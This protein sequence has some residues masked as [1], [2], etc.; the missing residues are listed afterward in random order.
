[1]A[2]VK[3]QGRRT[4]R[5]VFGIA[6]ALLALAPAAQAQTRPE[7]V[8][9]QARVVLQSDLDLPGNDLS[10]IRQVGQDA[11]VQAC[12]A[13]EGCRALTWNA[14]ARACFLKSDAGTGAPYVGAQSGIVAETSAEVIA[15]AGARLASAGWIGE[16][17]RRDLAEQARRISL[18]WPGDGSDADGLRQNAQAA[19]AP[20]DNVH[21]LGALAAL[22][23]TA[24]DWAALA[25]ALDEAAGAPDGP[26][27]DRMRRQ[28][29]LA[30]LNSWLRDPGTGNAMLQLWARLAEEGGRG[31]D[32]LTAIRQAAAAE[33]GNPEIAAQLEGLEERHGFRV[34][35]SRADSDSPDPRVCV[36]F[37]EPVA[38]GVDMRPFVQLP[39]PAQIGR[40]HV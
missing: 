35:D 12:L 34:S 33:P 21:W 1:M 13:T 6:L 38:L 37:S 26:R 14:R 3:R 39:D 7:D 10:M 29:A 5:A 17:D 15:R 36:G 31:R 9:P 8:V 19:D 18:N 20:E 30:A 22:T 2:Q 25:V 11:C 40:A 23:D 4:A 27:D 24:T 32:A 28:A 16:S